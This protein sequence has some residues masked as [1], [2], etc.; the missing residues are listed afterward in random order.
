MIKRGH[1]NAEKLLKS[2]LQSQNTDTESA[3]TCFQ[4]YL[5]SKGGHSRLAG[6][7][8]APFPELA[9]AEFTPF[10]RRLDEFFPGMGPL[11]RILPP[12]RMEAR[13]VLEPHSGQSSSSSSCFLVATWPARRF[14][15]FIV[16]DGMES[17]KF[18]G[19]ESGTTE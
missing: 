12:I 7:E 16:S 8:L 17:N 2:E 13:G 19:R 9:A 4:S 18:H 5:D 1:W 11:M 6:E 14:N 10:P 3:T 15:R